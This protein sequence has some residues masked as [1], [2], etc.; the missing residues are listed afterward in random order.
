MIEVQPGAV[1]TGNQLLEYERERAIRT[2]FVRRC[3]CS[4]W[5]LQFFG[6]ENK[7]RWMVLCRAL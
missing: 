1:Q 4:I 5:P 2:S 3:E 7:K 6:E